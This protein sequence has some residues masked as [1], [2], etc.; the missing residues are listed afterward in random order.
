MATATK[1][2]R[3][4]RSSTTNTSGSSLNGSTWDLT[5]AFGGVMT[6]L[7]TNSGGATTIPGDFVV[8]ISV[9]NS[10]WKDYSR[11]TA[12][13]ASGGI[14]PFAVEIPAGVLYARPSFQSNTGNTVTVES[15]GHE[16]SSIG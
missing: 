11:Q 6:G 12:G 5:T 7:I 1:N 14:Y 9:D 16:I 4:L 10:A 3:T 13:T 15:F 2:A 8:Q